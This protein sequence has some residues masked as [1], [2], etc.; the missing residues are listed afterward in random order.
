MELTTLRLRPG[1]S[2]EMV[3]MV[4]E[5]EIFLSIEA[6]RAYFYPGFK[7]SVV[8]YNVMERGEINK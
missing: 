5:M 6:S 1:D 7:W 3:E 8:Q 4:L 2:A